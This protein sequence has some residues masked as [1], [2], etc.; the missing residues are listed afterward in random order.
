MSFH[1]N[2]LRIP[3]DVLCSRWG[4]YL[5]HADEALRKAKQM[6][7]WGGDDLRTWFQ[8]LDGQPLYAVTASIKDYLEHTVYSI[9]RIGLYDHTIG[10]REN[11]LSLLVLRLL[12]SPPQIVRRAIRRLILKENI[13][14][15]AATFHRCF[16]IPDMPAAFVRDLQIAHCL[17]ILQT[18][19]STL[20]K[21]HIHVDVWLLDQVREA[22]ALEPR[23]TLIVQKPGYEAYMTDV[24]GDEFYEQ[25]DILGIGAYEPRKPRDY[26]MLNP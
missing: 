26:K 17:L 13:L 7:E 20:P 16:D 24:Y 15:S 11:L 12:P 22:V 1:F 14:Y 3:H 6:V 25:M 4:K 9:R 23:V 21:L 8:S 10:G 2:S 19:P 5:V 18:D